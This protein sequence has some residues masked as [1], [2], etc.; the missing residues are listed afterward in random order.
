[1]N[2]SPQYVDAHGKVYN[3]RWGLLTSHLLLFLD[4]K[5]NNEFPFEGGDKPF[6]IYEIETLRNDLDRNPEFLTPFKAVEHRAWLMHYALALYFRWNLFAKATVFDICLGYSQPQDKHSQNRS[7]D[8]EDRKNAERYLPVL[9]MKASHLMPH[10]M[11][12]CIIHKKR[13]TQMSS[14]LKVMDAIQP[15][16]SIVNRGET[17]PVIDFVQAL[18]VNFDFESAFK[19]IEAA[20]PILEKDYFLRTYLGN[21]VNN[22]KALIAA[23]YIKVH[24]RIS[25]A[26]FAERFG[27]STGEV[28][29]WLQD[30]VH[31]YNLE[32]VEIGDEFITSQSTSMSVYQLAVQK[33]ERLAG[34]QHKVRQ[35][36]EQRD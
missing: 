35:R 33:G 17:H 22:A 25:T 21:F 34:R 26:S 32:G 15:A 2:I 13:R 7:D 3:A 20:K 18:Y 6:I 1:M 5:Q 31:G 16:S 8:R 24:S 30:N 23:S 10:L 12:A 36:I 14:L 28:N 27:I 29:A 9:Q 4:L 19:A 11:A